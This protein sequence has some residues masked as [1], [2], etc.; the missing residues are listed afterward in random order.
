MNA[1]CREVLGPSALLSLRTLCQCPVTRVPAS[2]PCSKQRQ[3]RNERLT[4]QA[5]LGEDDRHV[6]S[7]PD[8]PGDKQQL[9]DVLLILLPGAY[10]KC[11]AYDGL[12]DRLKV[13]F[14]PLI[15]S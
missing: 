10:M 14:T 7:A 12:L 2:K 15:I 8:L 3:R 6:I 5:R 11:A 9:P 4:C 1:Q 13:P